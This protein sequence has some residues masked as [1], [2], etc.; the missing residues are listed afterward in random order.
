[1]KVIIKTLLIIDLVYF[2][3]NWVM[4]RLFKR[5]AILCSKRVRINLIVCVNRCINE[6]ISKRIINRNNNDGD[7]Q[8]E[9]LRQ[10]IGA[11]DNE[12]IEGI[13]KKNLTMKNQGYVDSKKYPDCIRFLSLNPR[14]FGPDNI[15]K[16]EMMLEA[17]K[18][19]SNFSI[20]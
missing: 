20:R 18:R 14:G 15:E 7:D 19:N 3:K 17:T 10:Q 8:M 13:N 1:L 4:K 5:T 2:S 12:N 16:I 9:R 6:V 11:M